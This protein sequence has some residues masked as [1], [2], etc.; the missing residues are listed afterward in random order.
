MV[1][2]FCLTNKTKDVT[3]AAAIVS[4]IAKKGQYIPSNNHF[5]T[6]RANIEHQGA[7]AVDLVIREGNNPESTHPFKGNVSIDKLKKFSKMDKGGRR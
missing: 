3:I 2:F 5:D 4:T 1:K 6:T 7:Q